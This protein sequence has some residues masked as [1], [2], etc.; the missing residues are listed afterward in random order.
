MITAPGPGG[1]PEVEIWSQGWDQTVDRGTRLAHFLA[2]DPSFRGG[3]SIATG[4]V[5]G[6][7]HAEIVTG[8]GPGQPAE[9]RVFDGAGKLL[10]EFTPFAGYDGGISVGAGDVDA[11]GRA[12]I[13]VGTLAAPARIRVFDG[14]VQRGPTILPFGAGSTAGV[15]VSVA[16]VNGTGRGLIVAGE[17]SGSNPSLSLIDPENGS[18]VT[19]RQPF[20]PSMNGLRVG[21]G[22]LDRDGRDEIV[23]SSGFGG[24]SLVY[25]FDGQLREKN[26]F[27]AYDWLGAGMNVA[28]APRIGLPIAADARTVK[29][30]A[31]KRAEV[32]VARFRDA[33]GGMARMK[34]SLAWGDGT[35]ASGTLLPR[36]NGVYDVRG[37]RRYGR[38]G[39]YSV[40][41]TLSDQ[42]GRTSVAHSTVVVR[43][44]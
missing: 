34:T 10:Y 2:F 31:H 44:R 13:V 43:R 12:E 17:A 19:T 22:D 32:I 27:R 40:T 35:Y 30:K 23:A 24:D 5:D 9:V 6:G 28:V 29:L 39:R 15:E 8:N 3:V 21:A 16:D 1:P 20:G 26:A 25:L 33:A 37:T 42:K 4:D 11:D 14:S 36:G 41:V 7:G 38:A 18:V